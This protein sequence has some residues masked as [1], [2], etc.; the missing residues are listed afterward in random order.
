VCRVAYVCHFAGWLADR[1]R[2]HSLLTYV[3]R[4][5]AVPK[6][7]LGPGRCLA[8]GHHRW[9]VPDLI[10]RTPISALLRRLVS[11]A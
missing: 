2:R 9:W 4:I 1:N 3:G 7:V 5:V 10:R 8:T 6:A 11:P